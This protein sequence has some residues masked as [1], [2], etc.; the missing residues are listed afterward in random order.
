MAMDVLNIF[1]TLEQAALQDVEEKKKKKKEQ[2]FNFDKL[3]MYFGKDYKIKDMS[4]KEI[5]IKM[6]KIGHILKFGESR[7]F[8]A[9]SPFCMN[10]TS[11]RVALWDMTPRVDWTKVKD[12]EVFFRLSPALQDKEVIQTVFP[13][14]DF[15]DIKLSE[16]VDDPEHKPVLYSPSQQIIL[17][18]TSFMEMAEYIR[19]ILNRHPKVEKPKGKTVKEWIIQEDKRK[20]LN[21]MEEESDSDYLLSLVS[22]CINHPGFK[23]RLEELEDMGIYQFMDS[24]RRI[25]KYEQSTAVLKGMYSGFVDGSKLDP[26][27]Y[28]FMG[29]V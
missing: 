25:Q 15:S 1:N 29:D 28:N 21:Q 5:T 12:I 19:T 18:E 8:Q 4:G 10:S 22:S 2:E 16:L 27:T 24:V 20:R 11:I 23:Y 13:D 7:Y 17:P 3:Q 6:P 9:L 14:F 26:E